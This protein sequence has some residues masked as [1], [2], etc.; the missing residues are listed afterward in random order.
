LIIF[1][2]LASNF[3]RERHIKLTPP[4]APDLE[5]LKQAAVSVAV[6]REGEIWVQGESCPIT[7]LE[8]AVEA[9]LQDR[10]EKTVMLKID[11]DLPEE[12]FGP[13]LL[14]LSKAGAEIALIGNQTGGG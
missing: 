2:M 11:K 1:F 7:I 8:N 4:A 3:I 6:D 13:V 12:T 5:V 10:D 14:A 9:L